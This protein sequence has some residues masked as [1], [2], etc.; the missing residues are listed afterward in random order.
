V[1]LFYLTRPI[2]GGALALAV[3]PSLAT[4]VYEWTT[5]TMPSNAIRAAAGAPIGLVVAW[6][7][8]AAAENQVN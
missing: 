3:S 6:L 8:V 2:M 1:L 4:L 7:V 5:G